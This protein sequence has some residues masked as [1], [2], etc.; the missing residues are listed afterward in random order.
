MFINTTT[1]NVPRKFFRGI[2]KKK[3]DKAIVDSIAKFLDNDRQQLN[4]KARPFS[5]FEIKRIDRAYDELFKI[6]D[7]WYAEHT[8]S[9]ATHIE[10][11]VEIT[12]SLEKSMVIFQP[13]VPGLY[14]RVPLEREHYEYESKGFSAYKECCLHELAAQYGFEKNGLPVLYDV[15]C[16][17]GKARMSQEQFDNFAKKYNALTG[18]FATVERVYAVFE[19][20]KR[21]KTA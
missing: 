16:S 11:R 18:D 3:L 9:I 20:L 10:I 21:E 8:D 7:K 6:V 13:M 15:T 4:E 1:I 5:P 19:E 17:F 2:N 14:G 12:D